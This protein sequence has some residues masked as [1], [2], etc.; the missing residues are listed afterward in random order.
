MMG[1][2]IDALAFRRRMTRLS[3][4]LAPSRDSVAPLHANCFYYGVLQTDRT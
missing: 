3:L 4:S 1:L 2:E